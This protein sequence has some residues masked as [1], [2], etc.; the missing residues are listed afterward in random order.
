M[1]DYWRC[2][3]KSLPQLRL[4]VYERVCASYCVHTW[5]CGG[6][7]GSWLV[8]S[9]QAKP[10]IT[11]FLSL[12][13][14]QFPGPCVHW[15]GSMNSWGWR[16]MWSR[17]CKNFT[18]ATMNGSRHVNM[19]QLLKWDVSDVWVLYRTQQCIETHVLVSREN[20]CVLCCHSIMAQSQVSIA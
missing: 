12:G 15:G 7:Q 9:V 6:A 1:M 3:M 13:V 2:Y 11:A 14:P 16:N 19:L 10:N 18:M 20:H 5:V 8:L 17:S 4:C